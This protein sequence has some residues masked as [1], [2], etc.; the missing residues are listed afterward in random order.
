MK[1]NHRYYWA[2][3]EHQKH[4][5]SQLSVALPQCRPASDNPP[6]RNKDTDHKQ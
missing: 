6:T 2:K 4:Y 5:V 1:R 3:E